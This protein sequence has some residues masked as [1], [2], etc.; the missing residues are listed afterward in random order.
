MLFYLQITNNS[1]KSF[2]GRKKC[3]CL[4]R[5]ARERAGT[6]Q[7]ASA[8]HLQG[9]HRKAND[10][11]HCF[12]DHLWSCGIVQAVISRAMPENTTSDG[13]REV[14]ESTLTKPTS[15][16]M[17]LFTKTWPRNGRQRALP[18]ATTAINKVITREVKPRFVAA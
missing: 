16:E 10:L 5:N 18:R 1:R 11:A 2:R 17:T 15:S 8:R 4:S 14:D 7:R 3:E 9:E 13:R 12:G 6:R